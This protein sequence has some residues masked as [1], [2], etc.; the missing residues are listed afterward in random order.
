MT[1]FALGEI[2]FTTCGRDTKTPFVVVKAE[3]GF[4][5][6]CD[7]KT[8]REQNPKKKNVRH[9]KSANVIDREIALRLS[10]NLRVS[11]AEYRKSVVRKSARSF[12]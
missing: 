6:L 8:R 2:V 4:V 11:D 1:V 10:N 5:Y 9:V 3:K 7:G 12:E